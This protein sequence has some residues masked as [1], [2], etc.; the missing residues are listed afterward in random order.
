M[1]HLGK[2]TFSGETYP[3]EQGIL[4]YCLTRATWET[5]AGGCR[6]FTGTAGYDGPANSCPSTSSS[7]VWI[8]L[9][10]LES[11]AW[12]SSFPKKEVHRSSVCRLKLLQ[13]E[14][15]DCHGI[16]SV[17]EAAHP[18]FKPGDRDGIANPWKTGFCQEE[19]KLGVL[20]YAVTWNELQ[21]K[22]KEMEDSSGD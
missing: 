16:P 20:P 14:T 3:Q 6:I 10:F 18:H 15:A 13:R 2:I 4:K 8:Q 5:R 1:E 11:L 9:A 21:T 7:G 22:A 12:R 17:Q 19:D